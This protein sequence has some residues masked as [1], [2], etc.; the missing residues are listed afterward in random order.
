[1]GCGVGNAIWTF[2]M[3][4][5]FVAQFVFFWRGVKAHESLAAS[6]SKWV[7]HQCPPNQ[8]PSNPPE[9]SSTGPG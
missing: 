1:M 7:A 8:P 3:I 9:N 5:L 6:V 4:G 2:I